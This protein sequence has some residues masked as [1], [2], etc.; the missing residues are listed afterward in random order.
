MIKHKHKNGLIAVLVL[1][2]LFFIAL[3][4]T[5]S[6]PP[7][8]VSA[9]LF[10]E[11]NYNYHYDTNAYNTSSTFNVSYYAGTINGYVKFNLTS[12]AGNVFQENLSSR[13]IIKNQTYIYCFNESDS[14]AFQ[15]CLINYN[16]LPY[17]Y[18][19]RQSSASYSGYNFSFNDITFYDYD[20]IAIVAELE[21]LDSYVSGVTQHN[22]FYCNIF[23]AIVPFRI[24]S[25]LTTKVDTALN[26]NPQ[27]V[28]DIMATSRANAI[29]ELLP[30]SSYGYVET[31]KSGGVTVLY[32]GYDENGNIADKS[33][34]FNVEDKNLLR[35][36]LYAKYL[37]L[38]TEFSQL[39]D[40]N[41]TNK[42][43]ANAGNGYILNNKHTVLEA[44]DISVDLS[45]FNSPVITIVYDNITAN[46]IAFTVM[47]NDEN[48]SEQ[49]IDVYCGDI[50]SNGQTGTITFRYEDIETIA[51]STMHW[52][53]EISS[54]TENIQVVTDSDTSVTISDTEL[55]VYY[56]LSKQ[57]SLLNL[58]I[59]YIGEVHE[60]R[61]YDVELNYTEFEIDYDTVIETPRQVT[62]IA[63]DLGIK[64]AV[65]VPSNIIT[66][67]G[68]SVTDLYYF[69][70][71]GDTINGAIQSE[72]R[73][74][75]YCYY[76]DATLSA[77]SLYTTD[78]D[79]IEQKVQN[80]EAVGKYVI[81]I[82]YGYHPLFF[83]H[84]SGLNSNYNFFLISPFSSTITVNGDYFVKQT[85]IPEGYRVSSF[86]IPSNY[87]FS[88]KQDPENYA[89]STF[90][91][92][93]GFNDKA[94][95]PVT[96]NYSDI[97]IENE[98]EDVKDKIEDA[99]ENVEEKIES[100]GEKTKNFFKAI[101][102][103]ALVVVACLLGVGGLIAVIILISRLWR[104]EGLHLVFKIILTLVITVATLTLF[105]VVGYKLVYTWIIGL[106]G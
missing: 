1:I 36:K 43:L 105:Y 35:E 68:T 32:K 62:L 11:T 75:D 59:T 49:K 25:E 9:S 40:F 39:S 5:F 102:V 16:N 55:V 103:Y 12:S 18:S 101:G 85:D 44:L 100:V 94:I 99:T 58:S 23:S 66:G 88:S 50:S 3:S 54:N 22:D 26:E 72:L 34:V 52:I 33:F 29:K 83:V 41:V 8:K 46:D 78:K 73:E 17:I 97:S 48:F 15:S 47:S 56:D 38:K 80:G 79:E 28:T 31:N 6:A 10:D 89:D 76:L 70:A 84:S 91:F 67:V 90:S 7:K 53:F 93:Q 19:F 64:N 24:N 57:N 42:G 106:G 63:Y 30:Y 69:P 45:D 81:N 20:Y 2:G 82:E 4:L 27:E 13:Q 96:V 71:Y 98:G 92:N 86:T 87:L 60:S 21:T 104:K 61:L 74:L 14:S 95:I 51:A 65:A 77:P 37:L